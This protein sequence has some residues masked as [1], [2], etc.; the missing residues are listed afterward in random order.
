MAVGL[1]GCGNIVNILKIE[2]AKFADKPV[3]EFERKSGIKD[4]LKYL[5]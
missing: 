4:D 3:V 5:A 1:V 2:M